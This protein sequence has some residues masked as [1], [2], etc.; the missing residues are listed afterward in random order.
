MG[1][2]VLC[3]GLLVASVAPAFAQPGFPS[4]Y[5]GQQTPG[6]VSTDVLPQLREVTFKQRLDQR[7]P[8]DA[9]F[10]DESG[11]A[12]TLGDFFGR[13]PVVLA[14]VYYQCPMLCSQVMNGL[15]SAAKALPFAAGKD[16][17]VVLVS[18]DPRDTPE[19][20]AAKKRDHLGR[21]PEGD[22][23]AW[24]LLTGEEAAIRRVTSAAGFTYRWD[25]LTGQFAHVSGILVAT[26][27]GRLSR[28][29]YG[30]E[31]SPKELRLALVDSGEGRVG[32]LIDELF[33][34]CFHYDPE[35]GR[36]GLLVMN[37]VRLGGVLTVLFI[38]AYI[39]VMRLRESHPPVGR[40]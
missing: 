6:P 1:R 17:E 31:F 8:L 21:W 5:A 25:E 26:S 15:S 35:S 34:Y 38:G 14:F 20:A 16:F 13:R 27:D 29:F 39:V 22:A 32:S 11:R 18:F 7:L 9:A 4:G 28:Y 33:L 37:L 24:H 3:A 2:H 40:A 19:I 10:R 12:V 30:V 23:A 36:Y